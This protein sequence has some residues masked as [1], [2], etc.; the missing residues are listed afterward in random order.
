ME[1]GDKIGK[2]RRR[3]STV[4]TVTATPVHETAGTFNMKKL[5]SKVTPPTKGRRKGRKGSD[6]QYAHPSVQSTTPPR[7]RS[8]TPIPTHYPFTSEPRLTED[9][10]MLTPLHNDTTLAHSL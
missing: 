4:R 9:Q 7:A 8:A 6:I 3:N 2:S 10:H 5:C 1:R